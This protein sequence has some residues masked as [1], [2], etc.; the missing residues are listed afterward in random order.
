M[1]A[2]LDLAA[3]RAYEEMTGKDDFY[4]RLI[5][6]ERDSPPPPPEGDDWDFDDDDEVARRFPK[7]WALYDPS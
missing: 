7:L 1:E 6:E 3:V 5:R 2:N 4:D